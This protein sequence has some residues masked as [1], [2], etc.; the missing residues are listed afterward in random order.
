LRETNPMADNDSR[1]SGDPLAELA[2]L[3]GQAGFHSPT[4]NSF[5]KEMAS[6]SYD[7]GFR[8]ETASQSY[9][10]PLGVPPADQRPSSPS[11]L[12]QARES[13]EHHHSDRAY[14][15]APDGSPYDA[16]DE[17]FA[18]DE[19]Y[20]NEA[21]RVRRRSSLALVMAIFGLVVVGTAGAFTYRAMFGGSIPLPPPI[22]KASNEPSKIAPASSGSQ[23]KNSDASQAGSA[24]TDSI[25]NL[26]TGHSLPPGMD[27]QAA[28]MP[29][30]ADEAK[31]NEAPPRGV[32]AGP[33]PVRATPSDRAGQMDVTAES[34]GPNMIGAP[35]ALPNA[36]STE[37]AAP[38]NSATGYAVQVTAER[39]ESN[40][41]AAFRALQ[42]KYPNQLGGRE[43]IIRRVDLG[44]KGTYYRALVGPF[45]SAEKAAALCSGLKA[46]GGNCL[47]QKQ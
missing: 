32:S 30:A 40:A 25:K 19:E 9:D 8:E 42:A 34:N 39:T 47:V 46:A 43:W 12:E 4:D 45:A 13:A 44:A 17:P 5:R 36:N 3:I 28:P 11:V 15:H 7:D 26:A 35:T 29:P 14:E 18:A 1:S 10:E 22:I 16:N 23:A 27:T 20:E 6:H 21:P 2:R 24:D 33:P 41:Q 38:S 37:A 31:P